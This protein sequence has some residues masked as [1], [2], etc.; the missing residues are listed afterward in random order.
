MQRFE[1]TFTQGKSVYNNNAVIGFAVFVKKKKKSA[2]KGRKEQGCHEQ[3]LVTFCT[4]GRG[5]GG[6]SENTCC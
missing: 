4:T 5:A 3:D 2:Q 1:L 6:F